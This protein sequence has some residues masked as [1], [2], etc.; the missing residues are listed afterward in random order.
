LIVR[1][2]I[3]LIRAPDR[4]TLTDFR[5]THYT[6]KGNKYVRFEQYFKREFNEGSETDPVFWMGYR[7]AEIKLGR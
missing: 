4:I 1:A 6:A 7:Q 2:E 3:E 5:V